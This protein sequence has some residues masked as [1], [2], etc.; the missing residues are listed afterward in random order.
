[1]TIKNMIN[2]RFVQLGKIYINLY[3]TTHHK[4]VLGI[5]IKYRK[6]YFELIKFKTLG[7][8]FGI[9][10]DV[11]L[12]IDDSYKVINTGYCF[13][14]KCEVKLFEY[15][16]KN[17]RKLGFGRFSKFVKGYLKAYDIYHKNTLIK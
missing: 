6:R 2:E 15:T 4:N 11:L 12:N 7:G 3:Y 8:D 13:G 1:M 16:D 10:F 9:S 14:E 5:N 17:L